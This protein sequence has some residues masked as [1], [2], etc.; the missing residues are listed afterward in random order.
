[1]DATQS[2]WLIYKCWFIELRVYQEFIKCK[3]QCVCYWMRSSPEYGE[4]KSPVRSVLNTYICIQVYVNQYVTCQPNVSGLCMRS[5]T[6]N[7]LALSLKTR[8]PSYFWIITCEVLRN[9]KDWPTEANTNTLT[10]MYRSLNE[11]KVAY[12]HPE[13]AAGDVEGRQVKIWSILLWYYIM[14]FNKCP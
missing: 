7:N 3:T 10:E 5:E 4:K 9:C 6:T 1:M 14:W 11:L 2:L 13:D 12:C 8:H